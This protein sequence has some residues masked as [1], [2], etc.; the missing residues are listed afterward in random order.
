M[1]S[2]D[3]LEL[4]F[5]RLVDEVTLVVA[6]HRHVSGDGNHAQLVDLVKLC[7]FRL[8]GTR[9]TG[10]LVVHTEVVLQGDGGESLVLRLHLHSFFSLDGLVHTFVVAAA[11]RHG[12]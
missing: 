11:R 8:G 12:R 1:S 9:H 3:R 4:S 10:Q 7:S 2:R 6:D 5:L